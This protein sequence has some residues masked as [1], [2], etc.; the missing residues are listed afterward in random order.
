MH[1]TRLERGRSIDVRYGESRESPVDPSVEESLNSPVDGRHP[2][3]LD[4]PRFPDLRPELAAR[5]PRL[6]PGEAIRL[7]TERCPVRYLWP[8]GPGTDAPFVG[9]LED[10]TGNRYPF[11]FDADEVARFLRDDHV[12]VDS[13]AVPIDAPPHAVTAPAEPSDH[14]RP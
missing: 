5:I 3:T 6:S 14:R 7:C 13:A 1:S 2:L 4:G 8:T 12:V 10:G 11:Y 9:V